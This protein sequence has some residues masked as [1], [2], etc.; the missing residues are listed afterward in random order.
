M[1]LL[2]ILR[3]LARNG[4]VA[5]PE[6]IEITGRSRATLNRLITDA[7]TLLGVRIE[8]RRDHT[9]PSRGE[10]SIEDWGLLNNRRILAAKKRRK[11]SG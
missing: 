6:L 1:T 2:A 7:N 3:H 11:L 10:Y 4:G 9:L 5:I 8:W